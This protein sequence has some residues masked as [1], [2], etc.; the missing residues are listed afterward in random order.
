M[1]L[2]EITKLKGKEI[3]FRCTNSLQQQQ[4]VQPSESNYFVLPE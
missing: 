3:F 2:Q 1:L 4:K